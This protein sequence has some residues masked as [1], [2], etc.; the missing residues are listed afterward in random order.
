MNDKVERMNE[1]YYDLKGQ[2]VS[3][4]HNGIFI[5]QQGEH[6]KSNKKVIK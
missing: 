6:G 1:K 4:P 2:R 5:E 3:Q